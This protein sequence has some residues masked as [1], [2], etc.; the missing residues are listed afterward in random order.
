MSTRQQ[1]RS[2]ALLI[3][4]IDVGIASEKHHHALLVSGGCP[5]QGRIVVQVDDVDVGIGTE[6]QLDALMVSVSTRQ[7]QRSA[8]LLI[9]SIDI[10][11]AIEKE[12]HTL[13]MAFA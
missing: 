4:S 6:Q 3:S 10:G 2:A 7:Q 8:A 9:S 11:I 1:Q 12:R 5:V 13:V